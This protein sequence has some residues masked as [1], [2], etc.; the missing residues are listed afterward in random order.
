M[1]LQRFGTGYNCSLKISNLARSGLVRS[2]AAASRSSFI[3]G[4]LSF[5]GVFCFACLSQLGSLRADLEAKLSISQL[6]TL[7]ALP[8][9][10][11]RNE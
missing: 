11:D 1:G 10:H 5:N 3:V 4:K 6:T 7:A 8:M 2:A 9:S